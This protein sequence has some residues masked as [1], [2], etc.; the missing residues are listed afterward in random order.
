[1]GVSREFNTSLMAS[2][3]ALSLRGDCMGEGFAGG[4]TGSGTVVGG[5]C[6]TCDGDDGFG[7]MPFVFPR[8]E[9][10][11]PFFFALACSSSRRRS[12]HSPLSI[13][14]ISFCTLA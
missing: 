6:F 12:S 4:N 3:S 11:T 13:S 7:L 1:M 2:P 10:A 8:P 14:A 9:S 5:E